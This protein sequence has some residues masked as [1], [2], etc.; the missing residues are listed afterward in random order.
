M[1]RTNAN[2]NNDGE[3]NIFDAVTIGRNWQATAG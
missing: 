3:V 2:L 1:T